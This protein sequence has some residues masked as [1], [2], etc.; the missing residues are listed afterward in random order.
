MILS[1]AGQ[2]WMFLSTVMVGGA[3]G[4]LYDVFRIFRKTARHTG[5]A[6]TLEDLFF[7][8]A[9]TGLT[10]YYMLHRHYG[11]MRVIYLIGV[12]IG[13]LL[14]FATISRLVLTV[15]VAVINYIKRVIATA[16][17]IILMPLKLAASWL[18]PPLA[19]VHSTTRKHARQ[20]KRYGKGKLRK[21]ARNWGIMRKKV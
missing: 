12:T 21:T 15:F 19:K 5:L 16:I 6:V 20:I 1:M 18:A 3:I 8:V 13:I 17:R 11:E 7:W 4:L 2:A 9:A 10:F 14:Y